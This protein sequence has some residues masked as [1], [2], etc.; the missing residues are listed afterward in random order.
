MSSGDPDVWSATDEIGK[1]GLTFL[2]AEDVVIAR[3]KRPC[4]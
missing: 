3:G 4:R 2:K 1:Q